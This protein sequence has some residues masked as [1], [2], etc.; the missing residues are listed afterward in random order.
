MAGHLIRRLALAA[1]AALPAA[2]GPALAHPHVT[3]VAQSALVLDAAGRIAAIRHRW[4][5]DE[6]YSAFATAGMKTTADGRIDPQEL[7]DLAKLNVESLSEFNYFTVLKQGS[8]SLALDP[9]AEG[10][11]LEQDGKALALTFVLPLKSPVA[12]TTGTS[13]RV[14]DET[15]FVS[16]SFAPTNPVTIEGRTSCKVEVK[17]PK[18]A[19]DQALAQRGE[20]FFGALRSGFTDD[21]VTTVRLQCP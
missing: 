13:L 7:K 4:T 3:V 21:F 6:A 2:G 11:G 17:A 18:K 8:R 5:F 20:E 1:G 14:D 15:F 9:P 12:P 16:F 19:P 10:Y